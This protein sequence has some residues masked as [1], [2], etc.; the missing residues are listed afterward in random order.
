MGTPRAQWCFNQI[1]C[2]RPLRRS[3]P[4]ERNRHPLS[5]SH[6]FLSHLYF[7]PPP[8]LHNERFYPYRWHFLHQ[9]YW[10]QNDLLGWAAKASHKAG[11]SDSRLDGLWRGFR[12]RSELSS[13]VQMRNGEEAALVWYI[14]SYDLSLSVE[15]VEYLF[16]ERSLHVLHTS[17]QS[18]TY[19]GSCDC[20]EWIAVLIRVAR[21]GRA[22]ATVARR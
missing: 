10:R 22:F 7:A 8:R 19:E 4:G 5:S 9:V 3:Q 20:M 16:W 11:L 14:A 6:R 13:V 17:K 18:N 2:R 21:L 12:N 15:Q 1:L